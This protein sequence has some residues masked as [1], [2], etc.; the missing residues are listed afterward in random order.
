M[1]FP[2]AGRVTAE[3]ARCGFVPALHIEELLRPPLSYFSQIVISVSA[4]SG[5]K[6]MPTRTK[7]TSARP[8]KGPVRSQPTTEAPGNIEEARASAALDSEDTTQTAAEPTPA[9][10]ASNL[11][12]R[13]IPSFSQSREER[14]AEAAYW[15]A[16]RR[17]FS[18]GAELDDWLHAEKEIGDEG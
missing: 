12:R 1:L 11:K 9:V 14:I 5:E 7:S 10:V 16:E 18:P 8:P 17:G 2:S 3:R 15:R 13:D 4:P 6:H